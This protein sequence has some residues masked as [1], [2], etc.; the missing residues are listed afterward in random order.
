MCEWSARESIH[1][2]R[3]RA[4]SPYLGAL[5][6][7][8]RYR[9]PDRRLR[10]VCG[11]AR[12]TARRARLPYALT[13]IAGENQCG[14]AS[15]RRQAAGHADLSFARSVFDVRPASAPDFAC[16]IS[17]NARGP[18][19]LPAIAV[20]L[21]AF[22]PGFPIR[23]GL[24]RARPWRPGSV[25]RPQARG[26]SRRPPRPGNCRL[27]C[28]MGPERIQAD[29]DMRLCRMA[30]LGAAS[31]QSRRAIPRHA[32]SA[33]GRPTPKTDLSVAPCSRAKR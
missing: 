11:G 4:C 25:S 22:V 21:A 32:A 1:R 6:I 5:R 24:A 3:S 9:H 8:P 18:R 7:A 17:L 23:P 15:A 29:G 2:R 19:D 14:V 30:A 31:G 12:S 28:V 10:A 27:R 13:A 16:G 26:F 33:S 20:C